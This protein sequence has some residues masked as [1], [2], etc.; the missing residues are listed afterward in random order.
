MTYRTTESEHRLGAVLVVT[1]IALGAVVSAMSSLNV[2]I[3][4]IAKATHASQTQLAWIIDAYSLVFAALLLPGGAI[5]DRFGRRRALVTGLTI[6]GA[7]SLIAVTTSSAGE[8]I[9]LRGVIGIG[10]ALVMPAT[11]STITTTFPADRRGQAVGVWAAVAGGGAIVG[12][13]ASGAV[14]SAWSWRAV[15]LINVVLAA[16]ALAGT[17]RYV[18]ESAD[19]HAPRIDAVGAGLAVAGLSV[20]V[21]SI[22]EAPNRGWAGAAT[23]TG[24]GIGLAVL[25]GFIVWELRTE[26]PLL[27]P[28]L[29]RKRP[30]AG[31]TLTI[32]LAFF[33]FF[34]FIFVVM[35]YLQLVRGDGPMVAA[36][37]VI[38][39]ALTIMPTAR[40]APHLVSRIGTRGCC[41]LGLLVSAVGMGLLATVGAGTPYWRFLVGLI[42]LGAG[43][44]L[45]MTPA[46]TAVT[47][48][49]P[50]AL[51]GV[52]SAMNDLSREVGGALGIAVLGSLLTAVY[53]SHLHLTGVPAGVTG[54]AKHSLGAAVHLGGPVLVQAQSAFV[55][56]MHVALW[57]A[58]ITAVVAA[59]IVSGL[60]RRPARRAPA[61]PVDAR[62][63]LTTVR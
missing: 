15:F 27:D 28:R 34:G 47:D 35:Q 25:A 19:P 13:L 39:M 14:L 62:R 54:Q 53:S 23:L 16:V 8:L 2:A 29:F 37:S 21:Y 4:S 48:S 56:G 57:G 41:T 12:L 3:P 49:L 32:F 50:P 63:E 45:S 33:A 11:L 43:M 60:L 52:G 59:G 18:P 42:P 20:L 61:P 58:A 5:G 55:D 1:C 17:A 36:V 51:Q 30:F 10:A 38:P 22:I 24:L 31:G 9:V 40:L 6:F 44:G 7:A 26:A 46:T